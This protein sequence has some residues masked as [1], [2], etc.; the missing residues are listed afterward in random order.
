MPV[1]GHQRELSSA[2]VWPQWSLLLQQRWSELA[3]QRSSPQDPVSIS[4]TKASQ[5]WRESELPL[6]LRLL[7]SMNHPPS[8]LE[9]TIEVLQLAFN[10]ESWILTIN[11]L[12]SDLAL[13]FWTFVN[14]LLANLTMLSSC[15]DVTRFWSPRRLRWWP[16][17]S[18][19]VYLK[20]IYWLGVKQVAHGIEAKSHIVWEVFYRRL[21]LEPKSTWRF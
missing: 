8:S 15:S 6:R 18:A 16:K 7:R 14:K 5:P 3:Q 20:L 12:L 13:S 2:P 21:G 11:R 9:P 4:T 10:S 1:P 17:M 19:N